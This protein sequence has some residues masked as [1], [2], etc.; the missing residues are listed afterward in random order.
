M[1]TGQPRRRGFRLSGQNWLWAGLGQCRRRQ[2]CRRPERSWPL[3]GAVSPSWPHSPGQLSQT[4]RCRTGGRSGT[5]GVGTQTPLVL[6]DQDKLLPL[7]GP[8]SSVCKMGVTENQGGTLEHRALL[9]NGELCGNR[10]GVTDGRGGAP[11]TLPLPCPVRSAGP[12]DVHGS[13]SRPALGGR[14][15]APRRGLWKHEQR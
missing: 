10:P 8:R 9:S 4:L 11:R 2:A 6:C 13:P 12:S 15:E 14:P 5:E 1:T 7:S 3:L